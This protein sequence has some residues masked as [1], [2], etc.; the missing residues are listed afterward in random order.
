[1]LG[2]PRRR[3]AFVDTDGTIESGTELGEGRLAV[4]VTSVHPDG[5]RALAFVP[6]DATPGDEVASEPS[7][8]VRELI[9][10]DAPPGHDPAVRRRRDAR[11]VT[12]PG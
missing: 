5:D 12:A 11:T 8:T 4:T 9:G 6:G 2:R 10:D 1:M 7:V 3:L